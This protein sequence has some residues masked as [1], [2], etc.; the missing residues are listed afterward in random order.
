MMKRLNRALLLV[1]AFATLSGCASDD[2]IVMSPVPKVN[3][4]FTPTRDWSTS[5]GSGVGQ[6]Y[7]KLTPDYAYGKLYVASRAGLVKALDPKTGDT[8]W[9]TDLEK[10]ST[11]R[12]SG[13]ISAAY[14]KI[15][16][17]SENGYVTALNAD[18]GK[19]AW[20]ADVDGAVLAAPATDS[21]LVF[22]HTSRGMLIALDQSTGKEKW[23]VSTD[24]PTLTMRGDST[25]VAQGGAVFW[26]T[27]SGR[28]AAAII[29]QGQLAWQIPI[30]IPQGSTEID[31]LVDVDASPLILGDTL[32]IVGIHGNLTAINLRSGE[33]MWK[34]K[35]SSANN[36]A[37]DGSNIFLVTDEDDVVAVDARSGTKI[38]SNDQL[39]H[40]LVTAPVVI[41]DYVVV[42]DAE[43]YLYWIN[44]STGNFVAEQ[45]INSSGIA[46]PPVALPDGY[47]VITRNGDIKKLT[48]PE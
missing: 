9:E 48:L 45:E 25:P 33:A 8:I 28:L 7:S 37:T 44:R 38:W 6:F 26:G 15:Y 42:G 5:I 13:G 17:G 40:R 1:I 14:G 35:Y 47:V 20:Q 29:S 19:V 21:N 10:D 23:T 18:T 31:R 2:A 22:V 16:I 12:L 39:K 30:G 24:V 27:A 46:V 3:S 41:G 36:L 32:Y 4:Q 43:G 11:A 34:R